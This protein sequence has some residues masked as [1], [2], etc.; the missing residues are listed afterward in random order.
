MPLVLLACSPLPWL[1]V[2]LVSFITVLIV[3]LV[4]F[5]T[6]LIVRLVSFITIVITLITIVLLVL[7]LYHLHYH[8]F[9]CAD[10]VQA[11][12]WTALTRRTWCTRWRSGGTMSRS[13]EPTTLPASCCW[14]CWW[15]RRSCWPAS[16][17]DTF[18]VA[19]SHRVQCLFGQAVPI[20]WGQFLCRKQSPSGGDNFCVTCAHCVQYLF[21]QAA[22]LQNIQLGVANYGAVS[23]EIWR[24]SCERCCTRIWKVFC[25]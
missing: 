23:C 19:Y 25:F 11:A 16:G 8:S 18:H 9:I 5:I 24:V 13:S 14:N 4:S 15:R 20:R 3:R 7:T 12:M 22:P 2:R 1:I 21:G 10:C 6:A 17:G